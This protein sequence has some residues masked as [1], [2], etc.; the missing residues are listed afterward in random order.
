MPNLKR[1]LPTYKCHTQTAP[2]PTFLIKD[3]ASSIKDATFSIKDAASLIKDATF[4]IKDAASSIKDA[5]FLIENARPQTGENPEMVVFV[6]KTHAYPVC[7]PLFF[8]GEMI[9]DFVPSSW[10]LSIPLAVSAPRGPNHHSLIVS[11]LTTS[12]P[13]RTLPPPL[14]ARLSALCGTC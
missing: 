14:A 11:S 3:A 4:L 13:L 9:S 1:L 12:L 7:C 5:A 2:T 6:R 10:P 8:T